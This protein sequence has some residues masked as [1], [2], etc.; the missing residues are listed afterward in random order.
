[1]SE[2]PGF[3]EF[4]AKQKVNNRLRETEAARLVRLATTERG[5]AGRGMRVILVRLGK[6]FAAAY[7]A[8]THPGPHAAGHVVW[9][10][11]LRRPVAG[12]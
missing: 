4:L 11:W 5:T 9:A 6:A 8:V 2:T 1:M 3:Y 10:Y 12:R 7:R